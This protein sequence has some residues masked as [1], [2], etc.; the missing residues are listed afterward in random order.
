MT[1]KETMTKAEVMEQNLSND[2]DYDVFEDATIH[3]TKDGDSVLE[4]E[5]GSILSLSESITNCDE[6]RTFASMAE[7]LEQ[8]SAE[9]EVDA[10]NVITA[11]SEVEISE[12]G[13]RGKVITLEGV[14]SD[15]GWS[16][17]VDLPFELTNIT[18][19]GVPYPKFGSTDWKQEDGDVCPIV[20]T[21]ELAANIGNRVCVKCVLDTFREERCST[22]GVPYFV[23]ADFLYAPT[24]LSVISKPETGV[25]NGSLQAL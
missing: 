2:E 21:A 8:I 18:C 1:I 3:R 22:R 17:C 7:V 20:Y 19:N 16:N 11:A 9:E 14:V 10:D 25:A 6:G 5:D 4:Y 15:L 13:Y 12:M 24:V 23:D